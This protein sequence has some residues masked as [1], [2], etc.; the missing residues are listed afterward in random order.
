MTTAELRAAVGRY[1][2]Q[3]QAVGLSLVVL[4][5]AVFLGIGARK[6]I[7]PARLTETR[8]RQSAAEI[9][10]FRAAFKPST[11][12]QEARLMLP[13]SLAIAVPHDMR[14]SLAGELATSAQHVGLTDVRVRFANADSAAAPPPTPDFVNRTVSVGDYTI[15]IDCGGSFGQVLSFVSRVPSS[16][17]LQ[18][19]TA[20]RAAKGA[21]VRYHLVF[22]VYEG[23]S[24][25]GSSG[26]AA[27][28]QHG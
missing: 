22:A 12:E 1:R 10:S 14:M 20:T 18:R 8:L 15:A 19:I 16:A 5:V 2:M 21:G 7:A 26:A 24:S 28:G 27:R 4:V 23:E 6:Q 11:P 9:A 3:A 17:A 13:D 25:P